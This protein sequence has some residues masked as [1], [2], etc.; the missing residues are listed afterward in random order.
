M[1]TGA[2]SVRHDGFAH[3]SPG[4]GELTIE[5]SLEVLDSIRAEAVGG[6]NL[7][8]HG[9][10]EVG[11]VLFGQKDAN[12]ICIIQSRAFQSDHARGPGFILSEK[13]ELDLGRLI[14]KA[15]DEPELRGLEPVGWYRSRTRS[16][17]SL[18]PEDVTLYDRHFPQPWQIA[19]VLCPTS[20][21]PADVG[22]FFREA[23][24][25][26]RAESPYNT[27]TV[28]PLQRK[29]VLVD[30]PKPSPRLAMNPPPEVTVTQP[31]DARPRTPRP[32]AHLFS[33][34]SRPTY[35]RWGWLLAS[36]FIG[37]LAIALIAGL[38]NLPRPSL[39]SRPTLDLHAIDRD[40][41]V[42]IEWNRD[43]DFVLASQKASL[44]FLDGG[45]KSETQLSRDLLHN[46]R[47]VYY[48][49]SPDVEIRM[50]V[51]REGGGSVQ[52]LTRLVGL[53]PIP[54]RSVVSAEPPPAPLRDVAAPFIPAKAK[55][56]K[57]AVQAK[58]V[59]P[60]RV[61]EV[62]VRTVRPAEPKPA[63]ASSTAA[64]PSPSVSAPALAPAIHPPVA[65][66]TG[67]V[68]RTAAL[69]SQPQIEY[70]GPTSGRLIWT[71]PMT[72]HS[73]VRIEGTRAHPGHLTG[74]FPDVPITISA[75]A[76]TLSSGGLNVYVSHFSG[77]K[78]APEA[79]GP[80]NGWLRTVYK[81]DEKRAA[82]LTV[83]EMPSSQN[84]WKKIVLRSGNRGIS[85]IVIDWRVSPSER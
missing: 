82:D 5:Y 43:A 13:D 38:L 57:S 65:P 45:E 8:R 85:A 70:R 64:P 47:L 24:G 14:Q 72:A 83:E 25:A 48:R 60:R 27:F 32:T 41:A 33:V 42:H 3:W 59:N 39:G 1:A 46:G 37:A 34:I 68:T 53:P 67:D 36:L 2:R 69:A 80:G 17:A 15:A 12:Q 81:R 11:G 20:V 21:G 55:E 76:A 84:N 52:E 22:F 19:M 30:A 26:L 16:A 73:T 40:G 10:V 51:H 63:A 74:Q 35:A 58:A 79:P 44:S 29:Q 49:K 23:S 71:G 61:Q 9:G 6:L 77:N 75:H 54:T 50:L 31:P 66:P 4:D 18:S 78:P 62:A 56:G 7:F 28:L